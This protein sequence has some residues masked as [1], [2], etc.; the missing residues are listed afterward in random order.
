M[1]MVCL[2]F[3]ELAALR[4]VGQPLGLAKVPHKIPTARRRQRPRNGQS[5][6]N[7]F[8]PVR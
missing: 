2:H 4:L 5:W 7:A 3:C 8:G 6:C 1:N